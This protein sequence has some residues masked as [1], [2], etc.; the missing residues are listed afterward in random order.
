MNLK[1]DGRFTKVTFFVLFI[2]VILISL[3]I[4]AP[5]LA[6]IVV[7]ALFSQLISPIHLRL[8][9]RGLSAKLSAFLLMVFFLI[10]LLVFIFFFFQKKSQ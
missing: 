9:A 7:G 8:M 2:L 4:V 1:D 6:A 10:V 3:K 5:F